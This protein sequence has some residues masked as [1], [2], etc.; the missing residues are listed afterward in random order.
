MEYL[1]VNLPSGK[2]C[3]VLIERKK[4]KTCRLKV[5][6]N[7]RITLSLPEGV[8]NDWTAQFLREKSSWIEK[9]LD[10]FKH[11]SG[12]AA[13]GE[14]RTGHSIAMYGNDLLFSVVQSDKDHVSREGKKINI[15]SVDVNDQ[16]HL[17]NIFQRWWKKQSLELLRQRVDAWYPIIEK[18]GIEKPK[19]HIRKM[20]TLWGSCSVGRGI[21]TF[22]FYLT[23]AKVAYIDYVVLHEL[24]HFLYPNHSKQ[25]YAF[26]SNYMPDWKDRKRILDQQVV[27]G[28]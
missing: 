26:L 15:C 11:T 21:V 23:K 5:Y 10:C 8:D 4:M 3:S 14:I 7:E 16:E 2:P 25:F 17:L 9:K 28:L 6:P 24:T 13:T 19:V 1:T 20:S 27:H 12:Y 22:N 18:Y